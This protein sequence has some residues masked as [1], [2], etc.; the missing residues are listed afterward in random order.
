MDGWRALIQRE[1]KDKVG[2]NIDVLKHTNNCH[3]FNKAL[4][5]ATT[6]S[7]SCTGCMCRGRGR[8]QR[9]RFIGCF[10]VFFWSRQHKLLLKY[11]L[12]TMFYGKVTS[13]LNERGTGS[14]LMK[15]VSSDSCCYCSSS[16]AAAKVKNNNNCCPQPRQHIPDTS[17]LLLP[18]KLYF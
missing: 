1:G 11:L 15:V 17:T 6:P 12:V 8:V 4:I 2:K 16:V 18:P 5:R 7:T 10:F 9:I 14:H 3:Y 13:E